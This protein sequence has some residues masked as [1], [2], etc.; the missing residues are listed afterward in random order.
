MVDMT[1]TFHTTNG[2]FQGLNKIH[3]EKV[4]GSNTC[5]TQ[6]RLSARVEYLHVRIAEMSGSASFEA[7]VQVL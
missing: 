2:D 4:S 6:V 7:L 5:I 3:V 1:A